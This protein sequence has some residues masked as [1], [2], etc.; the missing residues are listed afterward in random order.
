MPKSSIDSRRPS[1]CRSAS[2]RAVAHRVVDDAALGQLQGEQLAGDA[3]PLQGPPDPGD[4]VGLGQAVRR[5]VHRDRQRDVLVQPAA[6]AG[7]RQVED[8]VGDRAD[9]AD[10]LGQVDEV[11]GRDRAVARMRP[12]HQR[13][14]GDDV[15][16]LR[17][18][19][20]LE[21]DA[22]LAVGHRLLE[23]GAELQPPQALLVEDRGGSSPPRRS[24]R[25]RAGRRRRAAS[26]CPASVP[27]TGAAAT[28]MVSV[29]S[30]SRPATRAR[31]EAAS[32]RR[33]A[34]RSVAA[35][36]RPGSRT[37]NCSPSMRASSACGGACSRSR[38]AVT[39]SSSS[40]A[41]CP[42]V[43]VTSV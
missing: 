5:E 18:D 42:S 27:C 12:A 40:L 1:A 11:V 30:R 13:L 8:V 9:P 43:S 20:R 22:D 14:D 19:D 6:A 31:V 39:S 7:Q 33:R 16:G 17:V 36:D 21:D 28:P 23:L 4:E 24:P 37:A 26:A 3:V 15:G 32:R 25:R 10:L 38:P 34:A 41:A 35:S 29:T 2:T